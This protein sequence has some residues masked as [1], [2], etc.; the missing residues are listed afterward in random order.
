M[1]DARADAR[2]TGDRAASEGIPSGGWTWIAAIWC[3]GALFDASQTLL[4][5]HAVGVGK[6]WLRPFLIVF[7][8]WLPWALATPF[9][10]ELAR[11]WPIARG[12]IFKTMSLHLAAFAA[13]S[14]TA[15]GWS[16]LL[17]V[18][19]DPWHRNSPPT[20]VNTWS[21]LLV[22]QLMMFVIAY[23]LILTVTYAVDSRDKMARQ[24][25][26]IATIDLHVATGL[27]LETVN[28]MAKTAS[29][30]DAAMAKV[31]EAPKLVR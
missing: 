10:V 8:S 9:V 14:A 11:R 6:A 15:E 28:G 17:R 12:E 22:E 30:T 27:T 21:D 24:M 18:I 29:M 5:M 13:I 20:F 4:T 2:S 31:K 19:F 7:V 16:A 1:T 26:E 3:A 25:T 23:A